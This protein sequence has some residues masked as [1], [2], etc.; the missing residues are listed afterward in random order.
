MESIVLAPREKA[1][2]A[3]IM[4]SKPVSTHWFNDQIIRFLNHCERRVITIRAKDWRHRHGITVEE[5]ARRRRKAMGHIT[6]ATRNRAPYP[7]VRSKPELCSQSC[8]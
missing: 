2:K 1:E 6:V 5:S 8:G 3:H 7:H 4:M